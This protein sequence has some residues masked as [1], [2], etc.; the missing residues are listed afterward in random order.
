MSGK[1]LNGLSLDYIQTNHCLNGIIGLSESL[2]QF[3]I[4]VDGKGKVNST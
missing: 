3:A 2:G 1:A 4:T